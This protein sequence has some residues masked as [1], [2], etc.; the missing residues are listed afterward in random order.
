M[1]PAQNLLVLGSEK[2]NNKWFNTE[3]HKAIRERQIH[4]INIIQN[5][6]QEN[7]HINQ[8]VRSSITKDDQGYIII[9]TKTIVLYVLH[10]IFSENFK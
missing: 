10:G 8:N 3:Y 4:R 9:D 2:K 7:I 5:A 6:T 1:K